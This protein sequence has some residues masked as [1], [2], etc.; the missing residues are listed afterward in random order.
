MARVG[1]ADEHDLAAKPLQRHE[2]LLALNDVAAQVGLTVH[3]EEGRVAVNRST[4]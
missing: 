3:D 4:T 2:E 1:H